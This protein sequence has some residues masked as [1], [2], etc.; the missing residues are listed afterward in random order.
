MV[1][2]YFCPACTVRTASL[3]ISILSTIFLAEALCAQPSDRTIEAKHRAHLPMSNTI[4]ASSIVY[5]AKDPE[6]TFPP[7]ET[8]RPP[9]GAP[10][11]VI[12]LIDDAGFGASAAFGG[13]CQTEGTGSGQT[14]FRLLC[15]RG[16]SRSASCA[17]I[18]GGQVQRKVRSG[19]GSAA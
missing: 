2:R 19:M 10:N 5:D 6:A 8:L 15:A 12:F 16:N 18:V 7:I 13:P 3:L 14:V 9:E 4:R 1:K 17:K 11:V